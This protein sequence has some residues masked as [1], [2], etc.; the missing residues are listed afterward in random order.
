M[1]TDKND[2][3]LFNKDSGETAGG[4]KEG[5][6][7]GNYNPLEG[8]GPE[9]SYTGVAPANKNEGKETTNVRDGG[10]GDKTTVESGSSDDGDS[11]ETGDGKATES[12]AEATTTTAAKTEAGSSDSSSDDSG[13][14][15]GGSE[16]SDGGSE[17][18]SGGTAV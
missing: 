3:N 16:S 15:D 7:D 18:D 2:G 5:S 10:F 11:V 12:K 6:D 9:M 13:D 14:S 8:L 1:K 17:S 4:E